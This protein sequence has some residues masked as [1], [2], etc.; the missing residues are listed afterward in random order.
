MPLLL[1]VKE[2][3]ELLTVSPGFVQGLIRRGE[4]PAVRPSEAMVRIA[5]ADLEAYVES[6]RNK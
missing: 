1:T 3:A 4:L 6:L 5:R 2:V